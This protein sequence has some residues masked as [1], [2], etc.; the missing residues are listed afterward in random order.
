MP[1]SK[2]PSALEKLQGNP[3]R[4]KENQNEPK[5]TGKVEKPNGLARWHPGVN[6]LWDELAPEMEELGLLT[7]VDRLAFIWMLRTANL[8]DLAYR[9]VKHGTKFD[10]TRIDTHNCH[11]WIYWTGCWSR[12]S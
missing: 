12:P 8:A 11:C 7:S 3:G 4:R 10:I 9:E 1:K 6:D 5:P 2:K